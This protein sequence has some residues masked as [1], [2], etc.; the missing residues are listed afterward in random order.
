MFSLFAMPL[1]ITLLT[2]FADDMPP[3]I[4]YGF[5]LYADAVMILQDTR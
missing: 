1:L 2:F 5:M 3:L 4:R